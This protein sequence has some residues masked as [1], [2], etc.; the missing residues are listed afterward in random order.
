MVSAGS[1]ELRGLNNRLPSW[2]RARLLL[3][4][5]DRKKILFCAAAVFFWPKPKKKKL[6]SFRYLATDADAKKLAVAKKMCLCTVYR[7]TQKM[8]K[9]REIFLARSHL[10]A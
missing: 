1:K 3:I 10:S 4:Y 6:F 8:N 7:S 9:A 2:K 5:Y